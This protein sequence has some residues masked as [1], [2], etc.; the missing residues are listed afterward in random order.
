MTYG[1]AHYWASEDLN[2]TGEN[3]GITLDSMCDI[4]MANDVTSGNTVVFIP[5]DIEHGE[6]GHFALGEGGGSSAEIDASIYQ[7]VVGDGEGNGIGAQGG[8]EAQ[9]ANKIYLKNKRLGPNIPTCEDDGTPI[10][11]V[12]TGSFTIASN[13]LGHTHT[14]TVHDE[15]LDEDVEVQVEDD[16][17][18]ITVEDLAKVLA[19]GK[20]KVEIGEF[21]KDYSANAKFWSEPLAGPDIKI[22][23]AAKIEM[24][25]KADASEDDQYAYGVPAVSMRGNC[26]IDMCDTISQGYLNGG[27]AYQADPQLARK[28]IFGEYTNYSHPNFTPIFAARN[29]SIQNA[30][31]LQMKGRAIISMIDEAF[32]QMTDSA[33]AVFEGNAYFKVNGGGYHSYAS[34]SGGEEKNLF[35][36]AEFNAG[37]VFVLDGGGS[38]DAKYGVIGIMNNQM[39]FSNAGRYSSVTPGQIGPTGYSSISNSA[40]GDVLYSVGYDWSRCSQYNPS[41]WPHGEGNNAGFIRRELNNFAIK[42]L[43][44]DGDIHF[45]NSYNSV[46]K[47]NKQSILLDGTARVKLGGEDGSVTLVDIGG[48]DYSRA[49]VAV[50]PGYAASCFINYGVNSQGAYY[51]NVKLDS[52]AN[53]CVNLQAASGSDC[54]YS[55]NTQSQTLVA[56]NAILGAGGYIP[57]GLQTHNQKGCFGLNC[58]PH[59]TDIEMKWDRLQAICDGYDHF[60]Q[61]DGETHFENWSGKII[62]RSSQGDIFSPSVGTCFP[63]FENKSFTPESG[64]EEN[65]SYLINNPDYPTASSATPTAEDVENY[66]YKY[67]YSKPKYTGNTPWGMIC[68]YSGVSNVELGDE[69]TSGA[70]YYVKV[71]VSNYKVREGNVTFTFKD[72][73]EYTTLED[74]SAAIAAHPENFS[75]QW[76]TEEVIGFSGGTLGTRT[77]VA[78]GWEYTISNAISIRR[79]KAEYPWEICYIYGK[80]SFDTYIANY[81]Y[82]PITPGMTYSQMPSGLQSKIRQGSSSNLNGMTTYINSTNRG[83]SINNL[84]YTDVVVDIAYVQQPYNISYDINYTASSSERIDWALPSIQQSEVLTGAYNAMWN[85]SPIVQLRD[86]ANISIH[87]KY[88]TQSRTYSFTST[89]TYDISDQAQ[90]ISDFINGPDYADFL[91]AIEAF[92]IKP[93]S[94]YKTY[95][96]ELWKI[97]SIGA[98]ST[99]GS[100]SISYTIKPKGWKEYIE[101]TEDCPVVEITDD[102]EVRFYDGSRV[103]GFKPQFGETTFEF[104]SSDSTEE[105]VSFTLS[106]LKALKNLLS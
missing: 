7:V 67:D 103:K 2:T 90:A 9:E 96:A 14:E 85:R 36:H 28:S 79:Q 8:A 97:L 6:K 61:I 83:I 41:Y 10:Q 50:K 1:S 21:G 102:S 86:S 30:P 40:H 87:G 42:K 32:L 70:Y 105:P 51:K 99:T 106:E 80:S 35:Q 101:S 16:G 23:G 89:E 82:W 100:Y 39:M 57:S 43:A 25:G 94:Y 33:Y 19:T 49:L 60:I 4:I 15:D 34:S 92:T 13:G 29:Q 91:T 104:S 53:V 81:N 18:K 52:A 98:G 65:R 17:W 77:Q 88:K 11:D 58:S 26:L 22:R 71:A 76:T 75:K 95:E 54:T 27:Q 38:A 45:P 74:L 66:F 69:K 37:S 5:G 78:T 59:M 93:Y 31:I 62:L 56:I 63:Y 47:D 64:H 84:I 68:T 44:F 48:S 3:V 12:D 55:I 73:T 24:L 72:S 20:S 46:D